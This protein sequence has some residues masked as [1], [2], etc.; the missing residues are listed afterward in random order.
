MNLANLKESLIASVALNS[1]VSTTQAEQLIKLAFKMETQRDSFAI[2]ILSSVL[3]SQNTY[4]WA[5]EDDKENNMEAV[6][7]SV[8]MADWLIAELKHERKNV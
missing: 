6:K 4:N 2:K 3:T 8:K 7:Y 1:G 5:L